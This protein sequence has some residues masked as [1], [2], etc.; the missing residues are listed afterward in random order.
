MVARIIDLAAYR[1]ERKCR[2]EFPKADKPA[3]HG[4]DEAPSSAALDDTVSPA[5][6]FQFWTGASGKRYVHT[7][8]SLIECPAVPAGNFILVKRDSS[9][10]RSVLSIGRTVHEAATLNLAEIRQR[11]ATLG[12]NEVHVH[13]LAE[14]AKQMQLIEFDLKTGQLSGALPAPAGLH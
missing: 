11:G 4:V 3:P 10:R 14:T 13:L 12:A 2:P 9:G 1:A 8:Y 7:I 6:R 5:Q